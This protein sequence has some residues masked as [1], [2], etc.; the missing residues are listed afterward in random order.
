MIFS[1][2]VLITV[3]LTLFWFV[4]EINILYLNKL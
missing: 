4:F 3:L 2:Y 1:T